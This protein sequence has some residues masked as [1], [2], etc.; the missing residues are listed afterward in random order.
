MN[1]LCAFPCSEGDI[2][3]NTDSLVAAGKTTELYRSLLDAIKQLDSIEAGHRQIVLMSDGLAED[4]AYFHDDVIRAARKSKVVISA[5]GYPRSVSQS[6]ALQTLRRLSEETGGLFIQAAHIDHSIQESF[7]TQIH[8][9]F[10]S[11][12]RLSF[13]LQ[14]I[15]LEAVAQSIEIVLTFQTTQNNFFVIVP[16][17]IPKTKVPEAPAVD[18]V[19]LDDVSDTPNSLASNA[20]TLAAIDRSPWSWFWY[21]L[22]AIIFSA[23]LALAL[24][25]AAVSRRARNERQST[26][27]NAI[28]F[29]YLVSANNKD[30]RHKLDRTPWRIGRSRS[31]ELRLNDTS[32]SRLHAEIRRDALG[33]F[34]V[35]D[36]ESLNGVFVNGEPVDMAHLEENDRVEIGDVG[37]IFTLR[38]EEYDQQEPTAYIHTLTPR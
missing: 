24:S 35:Q 9:V 13:D 15:P 29:A 3:I 22:P 28:S 33:Q 23:I 8:S 11:V 12:G 14:K 31:S 32:V 10:S 7:F 34:T 21:G 25:Y 38:D 26:D 27:I 5:I 30:V 36:M 18:P 19:A 20:V 4:L 2:A 6:V 16:I 17:V 37:F 1:I